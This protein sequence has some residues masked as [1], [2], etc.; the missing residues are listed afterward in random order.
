MATLIQGGALEISQARFLALPQT[1]TLIW[2]QCHLD[3]TLYIIFVKP[4]FFFQ[5]D[6][7]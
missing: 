2:S 7:R 6:A 3:S 5:K 4:I 1:L